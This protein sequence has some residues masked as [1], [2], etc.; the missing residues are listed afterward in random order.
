MHWC[1]GL[2]ASGSTWV[3]NAVRKT[4]AVVVPQRPVVG[5]FIT[6]NDELD[7]LDEP[8]ILPV[9]KSHDTDQ[10]AAERLSRQTDA[11]WLSIRDPRDCVTSL[12]LYQHYRFDL[13]LQ[14][15]E[16]TARFCA[17]FAG[18]Q[19]ARLLRYEAGFIDDPA[20]IDAIAQAFG[21]PLA[22]AERS[23]IFAATRRGATEALIAGI[24]TLPGAL[25][26]ARSGDVVDLDTQWHRHHANRSGEIGRWRHMLTT[27]QVV[28]IEQ[29]LQDWMAAF[30]YRPEV[31]RY[32]LSVG[33]YGLIGP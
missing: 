3:Y 4:A 15:V 24:E 27:P 30:G 31:A 19:Q 22:A 26:D 9:V 6:R 11:L 33:T 8:G 21:V 32:R 28:S 17:R 16:T 1:L 5:R 7:F 13:A 12:M 23:A 10:A 29:N 2:Y 20:T 25:L 14:A 18:H